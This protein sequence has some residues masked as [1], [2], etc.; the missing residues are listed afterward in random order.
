MIGDAVQGWDLAKAVELTWLGGGRF[1]TTTDFKNDIFRFYSAPDWG[2]GFGN[3]TY[4]A[5][6]KIDAAFED[7]GDGDHNFNFVAIP[8]SYKIAVDVDDITI[9]MTKQ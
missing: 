6:G 5:N 1:E 3:Y 4:F 8:G 9:V 2:A 7:K